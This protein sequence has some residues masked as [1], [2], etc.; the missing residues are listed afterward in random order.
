ML[1]QIKM[2]IVI[3]ISILTLNSSVYAVP[4]AM[5]ANAVSTDAKEAAIYKAK[6]KPHRKILM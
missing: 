3:I 5:N 1:K 6:S 2:S 4:I